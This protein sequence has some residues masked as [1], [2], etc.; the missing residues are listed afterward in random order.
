MKLFF[1]G[2]LFILLCAQCSKSAQDTGSSRLNMA[3]SCTNGNCVGPN[4]YIQLISKNTGENYITAN[5]LAA[6]D[7]ELRNASDRLINYNVSI[8]SPN[9]DLSDV[10]VFPVTERNKV[11]LR[12]KKSIEI[13]IAY[14]SV[15]TDAGIT[16]SN[17]SV[18]GYAF[19][20]SGV[21]NNYLL[22]IRI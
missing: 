8:T 3:A 10:V 9:E 1:S 11:I 17:F 19:T 13:E 6:S 22:K 4:F 15:I 14:S 5:H 7:I 12:I 2:L 18:K 20:A 16:L 21:N